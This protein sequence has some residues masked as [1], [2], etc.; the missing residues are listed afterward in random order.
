MAL[1]AIGVGYYAKGRDSTHMEGLDYMNYI[2]YFTLE[3]IIF[4]VIIGIFGWVIDYLKSHN[5]GS[6]GVTLIVVALALIITPLMYAQILY[7]GRAFSSN[8][9]AADIQ[10]DTAASGDFQ[11]NSA[12]VESYNK[13]NSGFPYE[14]L[15]VPHF[16][17]RYRLIFEVNCTNFTVG[18]STNVQLYN[19][20]TATLEGFNIRRESVTGV[21]SPE[22]QPGSFTTS[23]PKTLIFNNVP[24]NLDSNDEQILYFN[25]TLKSSA[26][27]LLAS[28]IVHTDPSLS[29]WTLDTAV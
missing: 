29:Y 3:A 1:L 10:I 28:W 5:K 27:A 15:R 19:S 20:T 2:G 16:K 8:A 12:Q 22:T 14:G 21:L 24:Q 6:L 9:D 26:G 25:L 18:E 7:L 4:V 17:D 23:G 13:L 11:I